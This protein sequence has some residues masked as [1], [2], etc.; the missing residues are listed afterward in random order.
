MARSLNVCTF[1]GNL[2]RDPEVSYLPSGV[3]VC[4]MSVACSE[5][6]RDKQTGETKES[7]EWVPLVVY[8]R[9]AEICG[10]HLKK[11]SKI[12]VTGKFTTRKFQDRQTGQGRYKTEIRVTDMIMLDSKPQGGSAPGF[13]GQADDFEHS[14]RQRVPGGAP[15]PRPGDFRQDEFDDSIPF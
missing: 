12:H 15:A 14:A 7:T 11:G 8:D 4:N 3:A 10:E 1:I 2:G 5:S 13:G 6:Y 9:L